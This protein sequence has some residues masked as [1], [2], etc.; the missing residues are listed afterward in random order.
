MRDCKSR[1]ELSHSQPF[2]LRALTN[3]KTLSA[4]VAVR[5]QEAINQGELAPGA[6]LVEREIAQQLGISRMPVRE[7]IQQLVEQGLAVKEHRRAAY[8]N[9]YSAQELEEIYSVRVVLEQ[10]V[11]ERVLERWTPVAKRQ[12]ETIAD[13]MVAPAEVGDFHRLYE[14]DNEF[15]EI[16]WQ[17]A[18][19]NILLEVVSSLRGR[20]NRFLIEASKSLSNA[21]AL[22]YRAQHYDL[23]IEIDSGDLARAKQA[24]STHILIA[25]ERINHYYRYLAGQSN[26]YDGNPVSS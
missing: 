3:T 18:R 20:I 15:H 23:I 6:R 14:L 19:H 24:I 12:L 25:K 16:I 4:E 1:A 13:A 21:D 9:P 5:L 2:Q 10:L 17:L 22:N 26:G 7:A 11:M 8:V